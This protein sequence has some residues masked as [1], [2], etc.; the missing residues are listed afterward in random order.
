[1]RMGLAAFACFSLS[2]LIPASAGA[3]TS[4]NDWVGLHQNYLVPPPLDAGIAPLNADNAFGDQINLQNGGVEFDATDISIPG[5]SGLP[6]MLSRRLIVEDRTHNPGELIGFGNWSL[7]IPNLHGVFISSMGW[8]TSTSTHP[9]LRCSNPGAPPDLPDFSSYQY[10]NGYW[11]DLPGN[12]QQALLEE[13]SPELPAPPSGTYPWITKS[14]WRISCE[15]STANGYPGEG[16]I[17]VSPKGVKY[18][19]DYVV[20]VPTA[21]IVRG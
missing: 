8:Q 10:W 19:F 15:S 20:Q 17:A 7:A 3:Q 18:H 13:P 5:N 6:V 11:L 4:S 12:G 9:N 1:M 21:K 14:F 2:L 16:F